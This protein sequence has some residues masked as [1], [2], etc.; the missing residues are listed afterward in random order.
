MLAAV[1]DPEA[2]LGKHR[3]VDPLRVTPIT[4]ESVL[5]GGLQFRQWYCI[6]SHFHP[7]AL[8]F[9]SAPKPSELRLVL[10][11]QCVKHLRVSREF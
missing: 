1:G 8:S 11:Y 9:S 4:R 6:H 3:I 7:A 2:A 5:Y 10:P